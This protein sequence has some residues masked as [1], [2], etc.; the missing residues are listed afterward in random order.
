L[1]CGCAAQSASKAPGGPTVIRD[2]DHRVSSRH[3]EV[4]ELPG[5]KSTLASVTD[6]TGKV[7]LA[8]SCDGDKSLGLVMGRPEGE[9]L[10]DPTLEIIWDGESTA[11]RSWSAAPDNEA[12]GFGALEG[13]SAFWPSVARLKQRPSFEAVVRDSGHPEQHYRFSLA[14]AAETIDYVL[15]KCGKGPPT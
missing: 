5:E 2:P 1:V 12:W 15:A 4:V 14:Q 6:S 11:E 3:W 9:T 10:R 8:L 13:H 7:L